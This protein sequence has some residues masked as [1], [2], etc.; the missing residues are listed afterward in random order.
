LFT[1]LAFATTE[2][3]TVLHGQ[4]PHHT[5]AQITICRT[6]F[7]LG[8]LRRFSYPHDLFLCTPL[9]LSC[10]GLVFWQRGKSEVWLDNAEVR[11]EGL[12][13]LVLDAR[14]NN[15]IIAGDPVDGSSDAV[16]VTGL[17]GVDHAKNLSGVAASGSRVGEDEA[18]G[19][20]GVNNEDRTDGERN[21]FGVDIGCILVVK[22]EL[23]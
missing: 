17:E 18:D 7:A 5:L 19:L 21:A 8:I 15:H 10:G 6:Y 3:A 9:N 12:G 23:Y 4:S 11:E 1:T 16:L 22:P 14:V 2:K 13:L 20:L